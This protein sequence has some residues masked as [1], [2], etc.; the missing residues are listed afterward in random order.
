MHICVYVHTSER[1][2]ANDPRFPY[3]PP[4]HHRSTRAELWHGSNPAMCILNAPTQVNIEGMNNTTMQTDFTVRSFSQVG[5][6]DW[7]QAYSVFLQG[8]L[9]TLQDNYFI[10]H[11][12]LPTL[13]SHLIPSLQTSFR[14][15]MPFRN[16]L[17]SIHINLWRSLSLRP[18]LTMMDPLFFESQAGLCT[19][20]FIPA[21]GSLS[22]ILLPSPSGIIDISLKYH[23]LYATPLFHVHL[24][25]FL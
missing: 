20:Q 4:S 13:L 2:F 17:L 19:S 25:S 18:L 14:S 12:S 15:T 1:I 16:S 23:K 10:S 3:L 7:W 24:F 22:E 9:P 5:Y 8:S 21:P 6:Q 11:T